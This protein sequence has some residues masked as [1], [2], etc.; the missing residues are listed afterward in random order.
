M[1]ALVP[2]IQREA[3]WD[4]LTPK[5]KG[6]WEEREEGI[7]WFEISVIAYIAYK[8][9]TAVVPEPVVVSKRV[10]KVIGRKIG[11][12]QYYDGDE[13]DDVFCPMMTLHMINSVT[14]HQ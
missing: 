5:E 4:A 12:D 14:T 7:I 13:K 9:A 6:P 3:D 1:N 8:K 2:N 10:V 11:L